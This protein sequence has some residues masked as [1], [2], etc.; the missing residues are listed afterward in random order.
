VIGDPID[1]PEPGLVVLIG[2]AGAG[3]TTLATRLFARSDVLSSDALRA[4]VSGDESDQS[5]TRQA[6][7]IL[8]REVGDRLAVGRLV[9]VDA[10]NVEAPARAALRRLAAAAAVPAVAIVIQLPAS[11]VHE[12]NRR[13]AGR[14]VPADIVDRHLASL[15]RLGTSPATVVARLRAEGFAAVHVLSSAAEIDAVAIRRVTP[16]LEPPEPIADPG[17]SLVRDPAEGSGPQLDPHAVAKIDVVA[18]DLER[19]LLIRGPDQDERR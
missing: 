2:P 9:V 16:S 19:R 10:T 12:R 4:A 6:F 18:T 15:D 3:K 11:E 14:I 17:T 8:H 5:A 7:G 13:R 1:V